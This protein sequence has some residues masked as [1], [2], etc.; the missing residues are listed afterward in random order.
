ML[1]QSLRDYSSRYILIIV[2]AELEARLVIGWGKRSE[3][4][5]IIPP[6]RRGGSVV[7]SSLPPLSHGLTCAGG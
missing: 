3:E 1:K 4:G 2:M 6:V 5:P 7:C